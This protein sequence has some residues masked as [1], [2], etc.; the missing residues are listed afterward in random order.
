M[1]TTIKNLVAMS[2]EKLNIIIEKTNSVDLL[3]YSTRQNDYPTSW[4]SEG[5]NAYKARSCNFNKE[6]PVS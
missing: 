3:G 1:K 4:F 6:V 5:R 2:L